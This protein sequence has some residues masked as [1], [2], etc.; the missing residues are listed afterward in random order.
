MLNYNTIQPY[1]NVFV[2]HAYRIIFPPELQP[3]RR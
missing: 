1:V 2:Y 3:S